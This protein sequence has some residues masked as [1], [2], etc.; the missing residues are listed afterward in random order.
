[1]GFQ[2]EALNLDKKDRKEGAIILLTINCEITEKRKEIVDGSYYFMKIKLKAKLQI[3][4][5]YTL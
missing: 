3:N 5:R 4:R 1:M 2:S